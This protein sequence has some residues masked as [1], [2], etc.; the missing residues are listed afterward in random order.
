MP[1]LTCREVAIAR[2]RQSGGYQQQPCVAGSGLG[3]L[4]QKQ[5]IPIRSFKTFYITSYFCGSKYMVA[6][7]AV[8]YL[9]KLFNEGN[10]S[11]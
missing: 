3:H 2:E 4:W 8:K 1:H 5:L 9:H 7:E 11:P 6:Y 10:D